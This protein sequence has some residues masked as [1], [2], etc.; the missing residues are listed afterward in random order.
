MA[1]SFLIPIEYEDSF[2]L[3][4]Y[5]E[6]ANQATKL[7]YSTLLL[8]EP[9]FCLPY[10]FCKHIAFFRKSRRKSF[11]SIYA[12]KAFAVENLDRNYKNRNICIL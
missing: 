2:Y 10:S 1:I 3:F 4:I 9:F 12:I 6:Y 8:Y 5:G 7:L 11:Y